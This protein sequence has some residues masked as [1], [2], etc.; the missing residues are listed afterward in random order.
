MSHKFKE[1]EMVKIDPD[2]YARYR[3]KVGVLIDKAP[4]RKGIQWIVMIGGR[5][6]PYYIDESDMCL[7]G[8]A[9]A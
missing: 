4:I 1:G 2:L 9:S 5:V 6:H 8:E 3:D 7:A